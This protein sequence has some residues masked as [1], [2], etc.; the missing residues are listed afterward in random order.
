VDYVDSGVSNALAFRHDGYS[1]IGITIPLMYAI[2][3]E[4]HL[5]SRSV[6]MASRL[7][8]R[9]QDEDDR[10]GLR[11]V[12]FRTTLFFVVLHEWTHHIHGHVRR[13]GSDSA[14]FNEILDDAETGGLEMQAEEADSDFNAAYYVLDSLIVGPVR[15]PAVTLLGL[16]G[17]PV[18]VQDEV[19]VSCFIVAVGAF[20]FVRPPAVVNRDCV[21][22]NDHPPQAARM[23]LLIYDGIAW[24]KRQRPGL[25]A[26]LA[27][28]CF[29]KLMDA[30]AQ[31]TWGVE[32]GIGWA[33]QATFLLSPGGLEYLRQLDEHRAAHVRS[34]S[35][36]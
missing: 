13:R 35:R 14:L 33:A 22:K 23:L 26:R 5:L 24:C 4:C 31:V 3:D 6:R 25:E 10:D 16:D 32:G 15:V 11:V 2:W 34:L 29:H 7:G 27:P 21:Y 30:V 19:L 36:V 28:D 17:E 20:L 12:L 9:L 18:D 1:F 8:V